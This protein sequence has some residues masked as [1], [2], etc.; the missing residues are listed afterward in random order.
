MIPN[1]V[2]PFPMI[3]NQR[4][5][6]FFG[7][8]SDS[9]FDSRVQLV[10]WERCGQFESLEDTVVKV[11]VDLVEEGDDVWIVFSIAGKSSPDQNLKWHK[12]KRLFRFKGPKG[13]QCEPVTDIE[14]P[15]DVS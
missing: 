7:E 6:L 15:T 11:V 4:R 9:H 5:F 13:I 10:G 8:F 1:R 14:L 2:V 3:R 12:K